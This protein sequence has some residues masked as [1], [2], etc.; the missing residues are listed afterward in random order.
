MPGGALCQE[1]TT[2]EGQT[3]DGPSITEGLVTSS[4]TGPRSNEFR[5]RVSRGV[6]AAIIAAVTVFMLVI[7]LTLVV[8]LA[9]E[10]SKPPLAAPVPPAVPCCPDGWIGYQGKCYYFSET[11]GNWNNSQSHCSALNASLTGIDGDQE[12]H[13]LLG[14]K[15][16]FGRWIGLQREP[17]QPWRWPNGTEFDQRFPISGGGDCAYLIEDNGISSSRC[18]TGRS[19]ICSKSD[20]HTMWKGHDMESQV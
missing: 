18:G 1:G 5:K 13:F 12:K 6:P 19:W 11:E 10:K 8:L 16:F 15:G 4:R 20:A 9:V 17:G 2:Q 3:G 14:F 7:I